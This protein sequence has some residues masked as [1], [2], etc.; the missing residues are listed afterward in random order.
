MLLGAA[1]VKMAC[2]YRAVLR[3]SCACAREHL[4]RNFARE[5]MKAIEIYDGQSVISPQRSNSIK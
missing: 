1:C 3:K 4:L 5:E 2:V